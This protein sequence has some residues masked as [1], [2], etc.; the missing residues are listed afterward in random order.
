M[1]ELIRFKNESEAEFTR[2]IKNFT[3]ACWQLMNNN[4]HYASLEEPLPI[5]TKA[6]DYC[7]AERPLRKVLCQL[8]KGHKGSHRAVIFWETENQKENP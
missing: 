1:K 4:G 6:E 2:R 7:G 8:P 3:E 5:V